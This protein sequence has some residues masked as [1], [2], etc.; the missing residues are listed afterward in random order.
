M[1]AALENTAELC[2]R[3]GE[4][5][6]STSTHI[7]DSLVLEPKGKETLLIIA[8]RGGWSLWNVQRGRHDLRNRPSIPWTL[9]SAP[10]I[11]APSVV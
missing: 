5:V 10:G 9:G 1:V 8:E 7:L 2:K 6:A 3:I 11:A 4:D